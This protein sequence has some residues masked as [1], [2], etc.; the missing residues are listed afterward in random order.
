MSVFKACRLFLR[1]ESSG[2]V[3]SDQGR[4]ISDSIRDASNHEGIDKLSEIEKGS[5]SGLRASEGLSNVQC[6]KICHVAEFGRYGSGE[7]EE[8]DVATKQ[9]NETRK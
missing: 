3:Q 1:A 6:L 9:K 5:D 2:N 4:D 7:R 8:V